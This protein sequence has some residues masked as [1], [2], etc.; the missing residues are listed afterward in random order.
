MSEQATPGTSGLAAF[1]EVLADAV[2]RAGASVVRVEARRRQAASGVLWAAGGLIVTAD[3]VL[4]RDEDIAVGAAGGQTAPARIVGRDPGTDLALLQAD[5]PTTSTIERG[6]APRVGGFS[7]VVARPGAE[8]EASVGAVSALLGPV[9]TWRGGRLP[10]LIRTDAVLYPG[11]SGGA[12][13]DTAGR[14]LGLATSHFGQGAAMAIPLDTIDRVVGAIQAHGR[15]RRGFLGISSQPVRLP[16]ALRSQANLE[17]T[18]GLLVVG[19]EAGGPAEAAGF[20]L[21]DVLVSLGGQ[22]VRGTDELRSLLG[23][24]SV[25]QSTSARVVRGGELRDLALTVGERE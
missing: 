3:H 22:P 18:S 17:Q 9:R 6:Q 12:L 10:G 23:P 20:M 19:V 25:G 14:M 15:V 1:S 11:F 4:E 8:L 2:E 5:L 16:E 21:G 7:L 24:D 13:V